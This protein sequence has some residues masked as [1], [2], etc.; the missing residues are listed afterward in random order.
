MFG[1]AVKLKGGRTFFTPLVGDG[2]DA[3]VHL[4]KD[5]LLFRS[6]EDIRRVVFFQ[7]SG[8]HASPGHFEAYTIKVRDLLRSGKG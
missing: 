7:V 3:L 2:I 6:E 4:A 8:E 5:C 1:H